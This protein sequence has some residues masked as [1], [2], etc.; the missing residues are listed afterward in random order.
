MLSSHSQAAPAVREDEAAALR[1]LPPELPDHSSQ[2]GRPSAAPA[3]AGPG[4][5]AHAV[6]VG[7]APGDQEKGDPLPIPCFLAFPAEKS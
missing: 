3:P 7:V 4:P 2:P 6:S 1:H 5:D